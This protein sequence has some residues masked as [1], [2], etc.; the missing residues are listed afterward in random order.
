MNCPSLRDCPRERPWKEKDRC[1]PVF[2]NGR[3]LPPKR[4]LL[5][6]Y[7]R[8]RP[9]RRHAWWPSRWRSWKCGSRLVSFLINSYL[10]ILPLVSLT[11]AES[12]SSAPALDPLEHRRPERRERRASDGEIPTTAGPSSG[13]VAWGR[14][15]PLRVPPAVPRPRESPRRRSSSQ[16]SCVPVSARLLVGP[17]DTGSGGQEVRWLSRLSW[18]ELAVHHAAR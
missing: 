10:K 9:R 14:S 15:S 4:L 1:C 3:S 18:W 2:V 17:A 6:R 13:S 12:R 8:R 7:S 11:V 5:S 16:T